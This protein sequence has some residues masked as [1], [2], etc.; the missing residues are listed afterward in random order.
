METREL[1]FCRYD[2]LRRMYLDPVWERLGEGALRA[3]PAPG[4]NSIAWNLWH[5]ARV[6][7]VGVNRMVA[8][9]GQVLD[10]EGW[11]AR[12]GVPDRHQGTGQTAD[13]AAALTDALDLGALRGYVGAVERR[14]REVVE[15]LDPAVLDRTLDAPALRHVL[16]DEGAVL[17]RAAWLER[18]Y[19]GWKRGKYL[20]HFGL[21]HGY[22][23][24]GEVGVLA[25]LQS[26]DAFGF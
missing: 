18:N 9:R 26:V 25:S 12:M 23:H 16:L 21:T 11:L 22:H 15:G 1:F 6:E 17:P 24:A 4:L 20:V 8:D 2:P 5:I 13:E 3:R 10:D 14:T 7:D 19:S